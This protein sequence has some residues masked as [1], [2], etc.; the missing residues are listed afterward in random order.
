MQL[1][2]A[3]T[4]H[5][6]THPTVLQ[7]TY[8]H[9][10]P[11]ESAHALAFRPIAQ[12]TKE[13][14]FDLFRK[15]HTAVSAHHWHETELYLDG[16]EDQVSLADRAANPTREDISRLHIEW[17][18]KELGADNGKSMFDRLQAEIEAY[19]VMYEKM[20][21]KAMGYSAL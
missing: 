15:G 1:A 3:K 10:H 18:K 7:I 8:N 19:N 11:V 2:A 4:P 6:I 16:G 17:R 20:G 9:N 5:L 13:K 12:E 21:G 14:F